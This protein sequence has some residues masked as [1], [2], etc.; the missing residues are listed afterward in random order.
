M[1]LKKRALKVLINWLCYLWTGW[2]MLTVFPIFYSKSVLMLNAKH[3]NANSVRKWKNTFPTLLTSSLNPVR[4][5]SGG[6]SEITL[7]L[8]HSISPPLHTHLAIACHSP[9][10]QSHR[11]LQVSVSLFV[12]GKSKS[13]FSTDAHPGLTETALNL[14]GAIFGKG[15]RR[16]HCHV[17]GRSP[18]TQPDSLGVLIKQHPW[19][20]AHTAAQWFRS[21]IFRQPFLS[22]ASPLC[23][24]IAQLLAVTAQADLNEQDDLLIA[25]RFMHSLHLWGGGLPLSHL[26]YCSKATT[27]LHSKPLFILFLYSLFV[28]QVYLTNLKSL[29]P[30]PSGFR[31][32]HSPLNFCCTLSKSFNSS[33]G[34]LF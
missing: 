21:I 5:F 8:F 24:C 6:I 32:T 18:D 23:P 16:G 30:S 10:P 29:F 15:K 3:A 12:I 34:V 28:T 11:A 22:L 9:P 4:L 13:P 2:V 25:I 7:P 31:S 19:Q 17:P 33:K 14:D 26:I 20:R 1:Y 27:G